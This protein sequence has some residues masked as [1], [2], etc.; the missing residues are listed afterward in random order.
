VRGDLLPFWE[1]DGEPTQEE[2]RAWIAAAERIA[3]GI[4]ALAHLDAVVDVVRY[5]VGFGCAGN[6]I[7]AAR[8]Q[9]AIRGENVEPRRGPN[10]D[11]GPDAPHDEIYLPCH[12]NATADE[13]KHA[14]LAVVKAAHALEFGDESADV[15]ADS[16][17]PIGLSCPIRLELRVEAISLPVPWA[18]SREA[19]HR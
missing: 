18:A 14:V 12:P 8:Y 2:R 19:S 17:F 9:R 6:V 11:A 13:I 10:P 1:A 15:S 4:S 3:S 5:R 16:P 7:L